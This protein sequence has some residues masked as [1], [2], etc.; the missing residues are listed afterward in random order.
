MDRQTF[1]I[2]VAGVAQQMIDIS[3]ELLDVSSAA[4][5]RMDEAIEAGN[6]ELGAV[7]D[8]VASAYS[9]A[10][11][12]MFDGAEPLASVL[13]KDHLGKVDSQVRQGGSVE[14]K[15]LV[16]EVECHIDD[17]QKVYG[18]LL[19]LVNAVADEEEE[20][21]L[22]EAVSAMSAAKDELSRLIQSGEIDN[23]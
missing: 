18:S 21:A 16:S 19:T 11:S 4:T 2:S 9:D 13:D 8:T 22:F 1:Q 3:W 6:D 5:A 17:I 20:A 14:L 10:H 15:N 12:E 23:L 7:M